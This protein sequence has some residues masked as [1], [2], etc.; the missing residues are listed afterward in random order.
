MFHWC[1]IVKCQDKSSTRQKV[2]RLPPGATTHVPPLPLG[3]GTLFCR[4]SPTQSSGDLSRVAVDCLPFHYNDV[5]SSPFRLPIAP[6]TPKGDAPL[7]VPIVPVAISANVR[8]V[9]GPASI[10]FG[11]KR[12]EPSINVAFTPPV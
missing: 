9:A 11:I 4:L 2:G 6:Q 5:A 12:T 7:T 3:E 8:F 1:F 10:V